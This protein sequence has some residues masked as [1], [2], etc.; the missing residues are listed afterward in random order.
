M[1]KQEL[2]LNCVSELVYFKSVQ[3]FGFVMFLGP[4]LLF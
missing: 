3:A 1:S 4:S 2:R